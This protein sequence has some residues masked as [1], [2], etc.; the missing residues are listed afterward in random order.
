ML[1][2]V[3]MYLP[4]DEVKSLLLVLSERFPGSEMVCE[5]THRQW[6][7]GFWG[8]LAALKMQKRT[9]IGSEARVQFGVSSPNELEAWSDHIEFLEQW[10]YMDDDQPKIGWMRIFKHW[11]LFRTAQYTVHYRFSP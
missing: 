11:E 7:E 3:L 9:K 8:K 1:E 10:F 2:G 4:E 6:V 5:L